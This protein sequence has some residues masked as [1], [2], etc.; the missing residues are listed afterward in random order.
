MKALEFESTLSEGATLKVPEDLAG[1][2]P[3]EEPVRVIVL[4]PEN[5][6]DGDWQRLT[7]EQLLSGYSESDSIY[8]AV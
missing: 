7:S 6:E 5:A 8:D 4:L 3:K 2:I 1:Q